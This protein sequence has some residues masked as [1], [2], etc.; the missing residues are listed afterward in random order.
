MR[1]ARS[2]LMESRYLRKDFGSWQKRSTSSKSVR[3]RVMSSRGAGCIISWGM[4]WMW[5]SMTWRADIFGG[6]SLAFLRW[7]NS[8][9][10]RDEG[11]DRDLERPPSLTNR[12]GAPVSRLA[13]YTVRTWGAAVLRPYNTA[14]D[15]SQI[16]RHDAG[17]AKTATRF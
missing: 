14:H 7:R 6:E 4:M 9:A 1:P 10:G 2:V 8:R 5:R 13:D 12:G 16:R 15:E 3:P 17:A 11:I